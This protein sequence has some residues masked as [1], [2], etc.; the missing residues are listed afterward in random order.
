[1]N[2]QLESLWRLAQNAMTPEQFEVWVTVKVND[3]PVT[4]VAR[5]LGISYQ[6]VQ[7][8]LRLAEKNLNKAT[9]EQ[10]VA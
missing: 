6:A 4:E 5:A 7:A 8:R 10:A 3:Q 2:R 1:M 9:R